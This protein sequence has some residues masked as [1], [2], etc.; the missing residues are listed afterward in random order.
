MQ[1]IKT[2]LVPL[3]FII[4][5]GI[6]IF[7]LWP[8]NIQ[9]PT[10]QQSGIRPPEPAPTEPLEHADG[11][12]VKNRYGE[13]VFARKNEG[14]FLVSPFTAKAN[15]KMMMHLIE[16]M[17][18][19]QF[20]LVVSSASETHARNKVGGKQAVEVEVFREK[21]SVWHFYLG[22]SSDYTLFRAEGSNDIWQIR[23]ALRQLFVRDTTAWLRPEV[24]GKSEKDVTQVAFFQPDG[25]EF[26]RF[27][28]EGEAREIKAL[29]LPPNIVW[30]P[31][32]V[33]RSLQRLL[34]LR[35]SFV[36][37]NVSQLNTAVQGTVEL[38]FDDNTA[39]RLTLYTSQDDRVPIRLE[40]RNT[41]NEKFQIVP[42]VP[43]VQ[44]HTLRDLLL[45]DAVDL[46][47]PRVI[48]TDEASVVA[49]RGKCGDFTW[50]F[51][52]DA[53]GSFVVKS[54]SREF[55]LARSRLDEFFAFL[56]SGKFEASDVVE[57][58]KVPPDLMPD[59][60]SDFLELDI[61]QENNKKPQTVRIVWGKATPMESGIWY[62]YTMVVGR[63]HI[64]YKV[65]DKF[66]VMS[67]RDRE[68][69][70]LQPKD[71][72]NTPVPGQ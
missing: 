66:I 34:N 7:F 9:P 31:L 23:G 4:A 3:I 43:F 70:M 2:W 37:A 27:A 19:F 24:V 61:L 38:V 57:P 51:V 44:A 72:E 56:S 64:V 1:K 55:A 10:L 46:T 8:K 62:H 17:R 60:K 26:A 28:L 45:L 25:R 20:G 33:K 39:L 47:D 6:C 53:S 22:K 59:T 40:T 11:L 35:L 13:F 52:R 58:A 32:R 65:M 36:Q 5:G 42:Y 21:R 18:T 48:Q 49:M 12:R 16:K 67:C 69:W 41:A 30:H 15:D 63:N 29:M 71:P 14:W 50:D 54:S 68:S